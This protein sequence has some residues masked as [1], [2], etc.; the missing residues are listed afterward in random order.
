MIRQYQ[1]ED[2]AACCRLIHACLEADPL[3][4]CSLREKMFRLET[5]QRMNE[6]AKLFYISVY[7]S[8]NQISGIA[9]LDMNEIRLI[10]V[11]PEQ[12]RRGIGRALLNHLKPMAPAALFSDIFVYTTAQAA[13]FYKA[14][15]F[16]EQGP[17]F[18]DLGGES[19][20]AV[21]LTLPA[22]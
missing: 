7:E 19:L 16:V 4:S 3:L 18:F 13:G 8:E 22:R 14:C 15:G 17:Y 12:Q 6:R 11:S 2:A 10:Y 21:F 5:P 20:P 9:G 1:P